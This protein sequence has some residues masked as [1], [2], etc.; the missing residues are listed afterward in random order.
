MLVA[1]TVV[2]HIGQHKFVH[3]LGLQSV[4]GFTADK[5]ILYVDLYVVTPLLSL[6]RTTFGQELTAKM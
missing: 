4:A 5:P 6:S 3:R 2:V 1:I